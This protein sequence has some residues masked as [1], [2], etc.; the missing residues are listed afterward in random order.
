MGSSILEK[1]EDG[2]MEEKEKGAVTGTLSALLLH[3]DQ[4]HVTR[5][6]SRLACHDVGAF[7]SEAL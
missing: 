6:L 3:F 2:M 4:C 1:N 5:G 7:S